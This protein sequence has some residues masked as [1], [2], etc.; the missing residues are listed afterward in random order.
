MPGTL[1]DAGTPV[2][3]VRPRAPLTT[4]PGVPRNFPGTQTQYI[5]KPTDP[6]W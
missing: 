3:A 1:V 4:D 6:G 5:G 2:V